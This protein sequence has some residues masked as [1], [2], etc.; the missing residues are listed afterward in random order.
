MRRKY[1]LPIAITGFLLMGLYGREVWSA[2]SAAGGGFAGRDPLARGMVLSS[3]QVTA[4]AA[5]T[6]AGAKAAQPVSRPAAEPRVVSGL[7]IAAGPNGETFVDIA[8]TQAGSF[9]A[10]ELENPR[11]LV[12]DLDGARKGLRRTMF[13]ANSSQIT[14]VQVEQLLL[15]PA[16]VR[17]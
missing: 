3:A 14:G 4:P 6:A 11:R 7:T 13:H 15:H 5:P 12:V 9:R 8:T 10:T 16:T 17:V 1:M 2:S